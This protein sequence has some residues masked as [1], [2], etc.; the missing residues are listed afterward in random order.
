MIKLLQ[1]AM[2]Y[3]QIAIYYSIMVFFSSL[4]SK[5]I[6][7]FDLSQ[8]TLTLHLLLL[9]KFKV[10]HESLENEVLEVCINRFVNGG[11]EKTRYLSLPVDDHY[12]KL[13][14]TFITNYYGRKITRNR[15]SDRAILNKK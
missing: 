2:L 4:F 13:C 1:T 5:I 14:L 11:R 8:N 7:V 3:L 10:A 6:L 12:R 9:Q 15:L